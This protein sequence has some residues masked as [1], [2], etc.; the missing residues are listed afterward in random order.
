MTKWIKSDQIEESF[1]KQPKNLL[2]SLFMKKIITEPTLL[3][4]NF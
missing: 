4:K 1:K 3:G 2:L